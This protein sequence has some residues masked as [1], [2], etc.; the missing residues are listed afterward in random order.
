MV[1]WLGIFVGGGAG[2]CLRVALVLW[3]DPRLGASFP[4]GLLAVNALGCFA[5]GAVATFADEAG[6]LG[7]SARAFAVTG[8]L[9]GFTTFSSFGLDT[10]RLASAG[11]PGLAAANVLGSVAFALVGVVAGIGL[12][13]SLE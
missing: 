13:R 5:I 12:A 3:I 4:W 2:A 6:W 9:G 11:R 8:V 10:V 1:P 7:P